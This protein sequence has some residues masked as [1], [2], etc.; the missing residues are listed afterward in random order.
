MTNKTTL[1]DFKTQYKITLLRLKFVLFLV[2]IMWTPTL[3]ITFTETVTILSK[4]WLLWRII[5]VVGLIIFYIFY[6][7]FWKCPKCAKY[8]GY[9]MTK[10]KCKHC[11]TDLG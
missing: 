2:V 10:I 8:P 7:F 11:G 1:T 6:L 3:I 9:R 5:S 4:D